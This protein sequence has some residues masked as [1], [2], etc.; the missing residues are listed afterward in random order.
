M[1]YKEFLTLYGNKFKVLNIEVKTDI[2]HYP[3]IEENIAK[4]TSEVD[5]S[6]EII[7]SGFNFESLKILN[8]ID[9]NLTLAFLF[10]EGEE[11]LPIWDE[12][13]NICSYINPWVSSLIKESSINI[14][15]KINLPIIP[16]TL[17][18]LE[19]EDEWTKNS[20]NIIKKLDNK[21][22]LY[23]IISN[24]YYKF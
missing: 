18:Y 8:K 7:F 5:C 1:T 21:I 9:K 11:L 6:A 17:D 4:I 10:V 3:L 2:F 12:V 20:H 19:N 23:S 24:I 16:W 14:Y 13:I 22:N 15:K